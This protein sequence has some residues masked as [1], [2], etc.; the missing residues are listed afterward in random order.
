[1]QMIKIVILFVVFLLSNY[2]GKMIAGKYRYRLE[3]LKE[4]KNSL[5]IFKTKIK[6]TYEPIP[7]IF[8]EIAETSSKN[9]SNIFKN[10]KSQM[11]SKSA[12]E[13]WT[14][15]VRNSENNM[16][17]EDKETLVMLAKMLGESD[18]EGQV[19][20]IDIT[21]GFLEKQIKEAEEEKDKNEKLYRKLGTIMGIAIVI[22]L[23]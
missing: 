1:M 12:G 11:E 17:S 13:S 2:I 6:F 20:Q 15:A 16:K 7:E 3:E 14:D 19:S 18:L 10:A 5:N 9:I 22:V 4:M 8:T 23:I 21:L